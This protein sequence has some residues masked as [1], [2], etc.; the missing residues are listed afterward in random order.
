MCVMGGGG[1][2]MYFLSFFDL[3]VKIQSKNLLLNVFVLFLSVFLFLTP[4]L[5][6]SF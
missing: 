2:M 1:G 6:F 5:V 4:F 3:F